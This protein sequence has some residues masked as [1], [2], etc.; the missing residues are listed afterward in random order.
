MTISW[1]GTKGA[2]A[3]ATN[4][5][6]DAF[7]VTGTLSKATAPAQPATATST[8]ASSGTRY[9]QTDARLDYLGA[10][11]KPS[12]TSASAGSFAYA[13]AKGCSVTITFSGTSLAWIA[14]KS[15]VYG[16]AK[17]VVDKRAPVYLNLY[18]AG[19]KWKQTVWSTGTLKAGVHTVTIT[20]TG[21]K[22]ASAGGTNIGIDALDIVGTLK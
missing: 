18:S 16:I 5:G 8:S 12:A 19:T 2:H 13:D 22:G 7:D 9:Q 11:S 14:K 6:V 1:T 20:W 10:W 3:T 15:P 17:V 21:K 4:I